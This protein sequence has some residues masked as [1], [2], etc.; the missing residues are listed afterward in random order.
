MKKFLCLLVAIL[1]VGSIVLAET[2]DLSA[3]TDDELLALKESV[4]NE[5]EARSS[6]ANS[7]IPWY[8]YGIGQYLPSFAD[9]TGNTSIKPGISWNNDKSFAEQFEGA[10]EDDFKAYCEALDKWGYN[11]NKS[12]TWASYEASNTNGIKVNLYI[13]GDQITFKADQR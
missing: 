13:I 11:I 4:A 12:T 3:M 1:L 6:K 5:I 7:A 10:T 2:I 9:V 8:D